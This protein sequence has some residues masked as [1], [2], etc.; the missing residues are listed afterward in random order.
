[1]IDKLI[2]KV[3]KFQLCSAKSVSTVEK[4][5]QGMDC[6]PPSPQVNK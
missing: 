3:K 4:N 5:L 2:L 6:T 1:M